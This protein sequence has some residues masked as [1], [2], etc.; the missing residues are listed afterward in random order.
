MRAQQH[1]DPSPRLRLGEAPNAGGDTGG[2]RTAIA[3]LPIIPP[4]DNHHKGKQAALTGGDL[5]SKRGD[6]DRVH[7]PAP[8]KQC[9]GEAGNI[10]IRL[11]RVGGGCEGPVLSTF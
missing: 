4:A 9:T 10:L 11:K 5:R 1:P 3:Q 2:L 8:R 6:D 7:V